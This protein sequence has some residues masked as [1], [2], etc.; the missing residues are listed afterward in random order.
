[1]SNKGQRT[2]KLTIR[3]TPEEYKHFLALQ[4]LSGLSQAD[5]L[6]RAIDNVP[7]P[8]GR[9]FEQYKEVSEKMKELAELVK[10]IEPKI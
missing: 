6:M 1:M 3:L 7:M 9:V 2:S 10:G 5:F 8:D 4:R